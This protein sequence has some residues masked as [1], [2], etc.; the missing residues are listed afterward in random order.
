MQNTSPSLE[1]NGKAR[2]VGQGK[3]Q[4]SQIA[5]ASGGWEGE[6]KTGKLDGEYIEADRGKGDMYVLELKI[7]V[8]WILPSELK[9]GVN[10]AQCLIKP[11]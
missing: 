10:D 4:L 3:T 9:A 1:Q 2:L 6:H 8:D 7:L 11:S 5:G